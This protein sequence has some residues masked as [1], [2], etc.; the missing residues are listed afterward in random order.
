MKF[1]PIY[2]GHVKPNTI[3]IIFSDIKIEVDKIIAIYYICAET[4]FSIITYLTQYS[5]DFIQRTWS[6]IVGNSSGYPS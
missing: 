1:T 3:F 5:C 4:Q 6:I 2:L